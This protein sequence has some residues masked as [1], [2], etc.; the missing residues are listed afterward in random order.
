MAIR[1]IEYDFLVALKH[2]FLIIRQWN[3]ME[4]MTRFFMRFMYLQILCFEILN[5]MDIYF[6]MYALNVMRGLK[7]QNIA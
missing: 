3:I 6:V 1:M 7:Q 2:A 4:L 5:L